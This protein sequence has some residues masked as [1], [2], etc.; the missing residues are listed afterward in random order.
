MGNLKIGNTIY[1]CVAVAPTPRLKV[2]TEYLELTT[3]SSQAV[4]RPRLG[5]NISGTQYYVK[6]VFGTDVKAI[7]VY[8]T[9]GNNR[10]S[11]D[12][13]S[14][15]DTDSFFLY[16]ISATDSSG[17]VVTSGVLSEVDSSCNYSNLPYAN[18]G[19]ITSYCRINCD[20]G[21]DRTGNATV[22]LSFSTPVN[23]GS[24]EITFYRGSFSGRSI[25][26]TFKYQTT[27]DVWYTFYSIGSGTY[28][29]RTISVDLMLT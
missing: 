3:N 7:Q 17:S 12:G 20:T 29:K 25:S 23:L 5:T 2:G 18:D 6:D 28:T 13:M 26:S 11:E 14:F 9:L 10:Y 19:S 4:N 15:D 16:E 21:S 27:D 22:T 8:T 24:I 1:P